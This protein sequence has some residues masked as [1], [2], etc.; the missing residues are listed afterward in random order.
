MYCPMHDLPMYKVG[1][2]VC[3]LYHDTT[4]TL[5]FVEVTELDNTDRGNGGFGSSD[6]K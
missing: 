2:K 3:Q 6:K 5:D 1:E 4:Y